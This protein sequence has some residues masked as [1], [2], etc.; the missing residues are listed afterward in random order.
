MIK[1]Y[2]KTIFRNLRKDK[3]TS[4]INILGLACSF[5]ICML[6]AHFI[7]F[8]LSYDRFH[9]NIYNIYR[10]NLGDGSGKQKLFPALGPA[11]K[12]DFPEVEEAIRLRSGRGV[13]SIS[14]T[15]FYDEKVYWTDPGFFN[16]FSYE[17]IEGDRASVLNNPFYVVISEAMAQRY[18]R[19]DNP[20]GKNLEYIVQGKE[21]I[22]YEITGVFK[23]IPGNS[24]L[25]FN[26]LFSYNS[27]PESKEDYIYGWSFRGI[28]TYLLL[29]D[30]T[31]PQNIENK[32][33]GFIQKYKSV[34]RNSINS[35]EKLSLQ[36]IED[37]HLYSELDTDAESYGNVKI[38]YFFFILSLFIL[39]IALVNYINL[40][41]AKSIQRGKEIGVRKVNGASRKQLISQF[42][43]ETFTVGF[44]GLLVSIL[45]FR[46]LL[47][48]FS[49]IIEVPLIEI[50]LWKNPLFYLVFLL[51]FFIGTFISGLYPSFV[52]SSFKPIDTLKGG[53]Q[54]HARG[55][56]FFRKFLML[57][58]FSIAIAL[59]FVTFVVQYQISFMMGKDLGV[60][61]DRMLILEPPKVI[62]DDSL[63]SQ[64]VE[65]L[66]TQ[67]ANLTGISSITASNTIPGRDYLISWWNLKV[68]NSTNKYEKD[69]EF[70]SCQVDEIFF[71]TYEIK[72]LHG[73]SFS[74]DFFTDNKSIIINETAAK[75][76]G[77]SEVK[78]AINNEILLDENYRIIG[79]VKD[80]HHTSLKNNYI[81]AVYTFANAKYPYYSIKLNASNLDEVIKK[82]QEIWSAFYPNSTFSYFFLEDDFNK[83]Y[84]AERQFST[85]IKSFT[86]FAILIACLGIYGITS[87]YVKR[88]R[89]EIG[90]RKTL[91]ASSG[92]VLMLVY[93]D[94]FKILFLAS[95]IGLPAAYI[96]AR[97]WLN[98]YSFKITF[99]PILFL[100]PIV[101]L[102]FIVILT[103]G[104][105]AIIASNIKPAETLRE[106]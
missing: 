79:I 53:G 3:V 105:H 67:V 33:A 85:L 86:F 70:G 57:I 43:L 74:R 97:N 20:V 24:H 101:I 93:S 52:L 55:G 10:V 100:F 17:I 90:I 71:D 23:D 54:K 102:C 42:L 8:E 51:I 26:F 38:L 19:N 81:P 77:Y 32:Y 48:T 56:I 16:I 11:F 106:E 60:N 75:L 88:K 9:K 5:A 62:L 91:G 2:I 40:S 59:I 94:F 76:L 30:K 27:L 4:V 72:K 35:S 41:T 95:I 39:L 84:H 13:I 12:N 15:Q 34:E 47:P 22:I 83:Q 65:L 49:D 103:V 98:N 6:I 46:A 82:V 89:K 45:I 18:F 44:I 50:T 31:N 21:P 28:Y 68:V 63:Y 69:I 14:N 80:Y 37:I 1:N 104:Y 96:Y 25:Q 73:R 29:K 7:V 58:Q 92:N 66:K 87:F 36:K 99:S 64:K 61:I 78:E